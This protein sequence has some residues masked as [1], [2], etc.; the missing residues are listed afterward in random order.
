MIAAGAWF[1]AVRGTSIAYSLDCF[2]ALAMTILAGF[3][4]LSAAR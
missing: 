2:V 3:W 4:S 1:A